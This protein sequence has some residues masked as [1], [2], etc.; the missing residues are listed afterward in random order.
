MA[1]G[2]GALVGLFGIATLGNFRYKGWLIIGAGIFTGLFLFAFPLSQWLVLSILLLFGV[3]A[4]GTVFE[5]VSRTVLQTIVPDEMRGRVNSIREFV[6]GL[7][8]TWVAYGLGLGGEDLGVVTASLFLG[9]FIIVS[10]CF[11]ALF[12]PSFRKL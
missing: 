10:V 7:F 1:N 12:I 3:N 2:V 4:F 11:M 5:N 8:G 9:I 6:R